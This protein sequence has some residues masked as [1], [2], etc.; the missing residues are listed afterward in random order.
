MSGRLCVD[1]DC[2]HAVPP[3]VTDLQATIAMLGMLAR[4][5]LMLGIVLLTGCAAIQVPV[6]P[7]A[8]PVALVP[9]YFFTI[10]MDLLDDPTGGFITSTSL[11]KCK[12]KLRLVWAATRDA[13]QPP[14]L[15]EC[16]L[17]PV[18]PSTP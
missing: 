18:V 7:V 14:E 2:D 13:K 5:G 4:I 11:E 16:L 15:G 12:A 1:I 6:V 9:R 10:S 3:I 8:V 17:I